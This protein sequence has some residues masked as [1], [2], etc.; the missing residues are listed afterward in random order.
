M[1][2]KLITFIVSKEVHDELLKRKKT[3]GISIQFQINEILKEALC[4]SR[5]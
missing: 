1:A 4:K 5:K 2:D 3:R